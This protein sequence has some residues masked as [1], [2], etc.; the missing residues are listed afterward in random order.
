MR[1]TG[2]YLRLPRALF[3]VFAV[4]FF[5]SQ[6]GLVHA[7]AG[8]GASKRAR[9][10]LKPD[11]S[12]GQPAA[13]AQPAQTVSPVQGGPATPEQAF[14]GVQSQA[15]AGN[16]QAMLT[17]GG[18]YAEGYGVQRNFSRAREWYEKA[19]E[20]GMAEGVYNVGVCWETGMGSAADPAEAVGY[21][22]RAADEMNLP[23]AMFKMSAVLDEGAG[24]PRDEA[25][26]TK[27]LIRAAEARHPGAA[28]IA[29]V[30]YLDGLRGQPKDS[31]KGMNML[32]IAAGA[33]SVEAM[34]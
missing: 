8:S 2:G 1:T 32:K 25:G 10:V 17:L 30:I 14:A 13:P 24:V 15:Q 16:L 31:I 11:A 19:A 27:Y 22:R 20:A 26:A 7:A 4:L 23:Q 6:A 28:A 9:D 3:F 34:K 5:V 12:A 18:F 29:G 33:G 21:F